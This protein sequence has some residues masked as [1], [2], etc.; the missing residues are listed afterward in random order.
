MQNSPIILTIMRIGENIMSVRLPS[1]KKFLE[2]PPALNKRAEPNAAIGKN[3]KKRKGKGK[4]KGKEKAKS[5]EHNTQTALLTSLEKLIKNAV[6]R[7]EK[8]TSVNA[9]FTKLFNKIL[10]NNDAISFISLLSLLNEFTTL[11]SAY[12]LL[13]NYVKEFESLAITYSSLKRV[14]QFIDDAV[15]NL[16]ALIMQ[17]I[18]EYTVSGKLV[19]QL[20][21][22]L[23]KS[24]EGSAD[25]RTG[26]D[27]GFN[28][29]NRLTELYTHFLNTNTAPQNKTLKEKR[30]KE[31]SSS[32]ALTT[33]K[34]EGL[35]LM[36]TAVQN[37][38]E[39]DNMIQSVDLHIKN[40]R[41][42][43]LKIGDP[44]KRFL[45]FSET[46]GEL[47]T[48]LVLL[49]EKH[50]GKLEALET[51][52]NANS[53]DRQ[54]FYKR[55]QQD[56]EDTFRDLEIELLYLEKQLGITINIA[57]YLLSSILCPLKFYNA[58]MEEP[59]GPSA[60]SSQKLTVMT[61]AQK[62]SELSIETAEPGKEDDK[63]IEEDLKRQ[64]QNLERLPV[65]ARDEKFL[66]FN[67]PFGEL[68]TQ[69]VTYYNTHI[70]DA[71]WIKDIEEGNPLDKI[72]FFERPHENESI[73][74]LLIELFY[75]E[76]QFNISKK[77]SYLNQPCLSPTK[78]YDCLIQ[79]Y[80]F[81]KNALS[82][83]NDETKSQYFPAYL[84]ELS[85]VFVFLHKAIGLEII[86]PEDS[87]WQDDL[88]RL[89]KIR[90]EP[91]TKKP[92]EGV[93]KLHGNLL[94]IGRWGGE[95][96]MGAEQII[97]A[98]K[99]DKAPVYLPPYRRGVGAGR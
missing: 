73:R 79:Q 6:E 14:P 38:S 86:K 76:K 70:T 63:R 80:E 78:L 2:N 31:G 13:E 42:L 36:G 92:S 35:P 99:P 53:V 84:E 22:L 75:L 47:Y 41:T 17:F 10:E 16:R 45:H 25:L 3:S 55:C 46:F 64:V 18:N 27:G 52:V 87:Q 33:K 19:L 32:V 66:Y 39:E 58:L 68:Y 62:A 51:I 56:D 9:T 21:E 57:S 28:E 77:F 30:P 29:F 1:L 8:N 26:F 93:P 44:K 83:Q 94:F 4:G 24:K 50:P 59:Q 67:R 34:S 61:L 74:D 23:E 15:E 85:G 54:E 11:L 12:Q 90:K 60:G 5:A 98:E 81:V 91:E 71:E 97:P 69:F 7:K 40:L 43:G 65:G 82:E 49:H 37:T 48:K 95:F 96:Q 72:K 88:N 89:L 20:K